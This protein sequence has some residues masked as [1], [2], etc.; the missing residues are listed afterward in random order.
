MACDLCCGTGTTALEMARRGYRVFAVDASRAMLGVAREKFRRARVDVKT[1][2]ADMRNFRLPEPVDLVTCEFDAINH[3]ARKR[4]LESVARAVARAL[5]PGGWFFFD[6]NTT[7]AFRELWVTNWIV[8]GRGFFLAARG[9][10]DERRDKGWTEF[11]WFVPAGAWR[12]LRGAGLQ[13]GNLNLAE[14]TDKLQ[15][16]GGGLQPGNLNWVERTDKQQRRGGGLQPGTVEPNARTFWRRYAERYEQV[17]WTDGE[18]RAALRGAGLSVCGAWDLVRFARGE[19]WA[20]PG[21]RTFW[22]AEKSRG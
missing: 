4:D 2:R 5:Q 20:K 15:R 14:R 1:V 3:L 7:Q 13:P 9:G 6:A 8:Q 10:Y 22:L 21:N 16:R 19:P 11:N 18:I 17:A 12:R